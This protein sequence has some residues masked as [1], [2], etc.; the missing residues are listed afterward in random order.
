MELNPEFIPDVKR[1]FKPDETL[2]V[3]CRSGDR[4]AMAVN[5]LAK[6]GFT[7]VYNII[8]GMEGDTVDEPEAHTTASGCGT[9]GRTPGRPGRT[10]STRSRPAC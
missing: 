9:A 2:L 1:R 6:A 5:A 10:S 3:M 7:N 4:S 8:D